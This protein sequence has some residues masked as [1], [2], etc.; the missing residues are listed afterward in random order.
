MAL[1]ACPDKH[2]L[3]DCCL[4]NPTTVESML[5]FAARIAELA[6]DLNHGLST[7]LVTSV[8]RRSGDEFRRAAFP[9]ALRKGVKGVTAFSGMPLF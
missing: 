5:D 7:V 6:V 8:L 4:G 2:V 3:S 1:P 9:F